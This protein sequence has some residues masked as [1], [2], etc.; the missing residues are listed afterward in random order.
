MS[1]P[2]SKKVK[3]KVAVSNKVGTNG[4][5]PRGK[6]GRE[7]TFTERTAARY[8]AIAKAKSPR[9][10]KERCLWQGCNKRLSNKY[11]LD[12]HMTTTH[13]REDILI[14]CPLFGHFGNG[15]YPCCYEDC[16]QVFTTLNK[17]IYH[18]GVKHKM[19]ERL[20]DEKTETCLYCWGDD[21]TINEYFKHSCVIQFQEPNNNAGDKQSLNGIGVSESV[22][23][24]SNDKSVETS[25][26]EVNDNMDEEN[27]EG[28]PSRRSSSFNRMNATTADSLLDENEMKAFDIRKQILDICSSSEDDEENEEDGE[29]QDDSQDRDEE[30]EDEEESD[31]VVQE[32]IPCEAH[33]CHQKFKTQGEFREHWRSSHSHSWENL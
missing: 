20:F 11:V 5:N 28:N 6:V 29:H 16:Q 24:E 14:D 12:F 8:A 18:L 30:E 26:E 7:L 10:K 32:L 2:S 15:H 33:N 25:V 4:L 23:D 3:T 27:E 19:M 9:M 31:A 1:G 22:E 13:L 21:M 17:R